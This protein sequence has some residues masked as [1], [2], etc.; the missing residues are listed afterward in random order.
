MAGLDSEVQRKLRER[1]ARM[2]ADAQ[3]SPDPV[4]KA[5]GGRGPWRRTQNSRLGTT[6]A[7][8]FSLSDAHDRIARDLALAEN[9]SKSEIVRRAIVHLATCPRGRK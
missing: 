9:C 5:K 4:A 8:S 7:V 6:V 1:V 3:L 2:E